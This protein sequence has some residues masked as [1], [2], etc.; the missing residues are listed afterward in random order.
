MSTL[1]SY[2]GYKRYNIVSHWERKRYRAIFKIRNGYR[3]SARSFKTATDAIE[4]G[5]T[6]SARAD[7]LFK[8]LFCPKQISTPDLDAQP[9]DSPIIPPGWL[10]DS[11]RWDQPFQS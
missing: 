11:P 5:E 10:P 7:H 6:H 8:L 4:Y 1:V 2:V 3:V 9:A